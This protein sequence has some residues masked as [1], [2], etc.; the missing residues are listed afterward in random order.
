MKELDRGRMARQVI[1]TGEYVELNDVGLVFA[2]HTPFVV[3]EVVTNQLLKAEK[4]IRWWIGDALRFGEATYGEK[5]TQAMDATGY[6]Y[7]TLSQSVWVANKYPELSLR[8]DNCTFRQHEVVA[9]LEP[10]ER[11][12]VLEIAYVKGW[13]DRQLRD[14]VAE[15]K[16]LP[17][18]S[19]PPAEVLVECP[20]C[21]GTGKVLDRNV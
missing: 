1:E 19:S 9:A 17:Q 13:T 21:G 18:N 12:E 2:D 3:W 14:E 15:R 5:Y 4:S 6:S 8:K 10:D 11:E 16:T 20:N 7:S